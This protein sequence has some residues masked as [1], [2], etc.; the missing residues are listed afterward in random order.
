MF[1]FKLKLMSL[2]VAP[3]SGVDVAGGQLSALVLLTLLL[4][5]LALG[6]LVGLLLSL[7]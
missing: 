1:M 4:P 2:S 3:L 5:E 6:A 7:V